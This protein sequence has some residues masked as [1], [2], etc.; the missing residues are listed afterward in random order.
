MADAPD[1]SHAFEDLEEQTDRVV[2]KV[3]EERGLTRKDIQK[4]EPL[5]ERAAAARAA[6]KALDEARAPDRDIELS[7]VRSK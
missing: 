7:E 6:S 2:D 1:V 4:A 3:L 5:E